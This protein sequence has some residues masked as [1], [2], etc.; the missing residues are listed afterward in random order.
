[1][2][3]VR[4][5]VQLVIE[6]GQI[7]AYLKRTL[8]NLSGDDEFQKVKGTK[9]EVCADLPVEKCTRILLE[10]KADFQGC[11]GGGLERALGCYVREGRPA[12]LRRRPLQ[13][14]ENRA[15]KG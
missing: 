3:S 7:R 6:T 11:G 13:E 12:R 8:A 4:G 1:M 5:S 9:A 15:G 10:V 14:Q 2:T